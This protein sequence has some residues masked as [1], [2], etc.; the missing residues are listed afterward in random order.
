[1]MR[2]A[3]IEDNADFRDEVRF[4]LE[5]A[6]FSISHESEGVDL[7]EHEVATSSDVV[8]LDL[9]LPGADGLDIAI[10][11]RRRWPSL[12][13]LMLT[14]RGSVTDR[15]SGLQSG[16]DAYLAKPVDMREL[17]AVLQTIERRMLGWPSTEVR[18]GLWTLRPDLLELEPP[19]GKRISLTPTETALL[20]LLAGG[21][22]KPAS[23]EA[24]A[25]AMG[26][27]EPDF[28][29]RRLEVA[30]SRLRNKIEAEVPD[31]R[32]IRSARKR[33]YVF[34]ATLRM[35]AR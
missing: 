32:V 25:E 34:A 17:V 35:I 26:H 20:K 19:N 14:A 3:L 28:D 24:L 11:L 16:A 8:V 10:G 30:L 5:R 22:D 9:G 13:I 7:D 27:P 31:S 12:G 2:V 6:G 33:G 15:I 23:R 18:A 21:A 29:F 4:H 1:M